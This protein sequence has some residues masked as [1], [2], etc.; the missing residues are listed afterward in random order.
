MLLTIIVIINSRPKPLNP[1]PKKTTL[2][3]GGPTLTIDNLSE[4]L[5]RQHVG[6]PGLKG[7]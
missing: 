6:I 5:W 1:K 3:S 2:L 4:T 7:A